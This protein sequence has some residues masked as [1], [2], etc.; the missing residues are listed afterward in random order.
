[1]F[2]TGVTMAPVMGQL[3]LQIC[4]FFGLFS[5]MAWGGADVR[6]CSSP[7]PSCSSCSAG[8]AGSSRSAPGTSSSRHQT[9]PLPARHPRPGAADLRRQHHLL[10][11]R[12]HRRPSGLAPRRQRR[13][14]RPGPHHHHPP[15]A[16]R[17][18]RRRQRLQIARRL[19]DIIA[20]TSPS[21]ASRPPRPP[22]PPHRRGRRRRGPRCDRGSSRQAVTQMRP[23]LGPLRDIE[24]QDGSP[25]RR[26]HRRPR[27]RRPPRPRRG[28]AYARPAHVVQRRRGPPRRRRPAP[29]HRRALALPHH[30]GGARQRRAPLH[31]GPGLGHPARHGGRPHAVRRGGGV[32]DGRLRPHTSGTGLGLLGIRERAPPT[33]ARSRS[34]RRATRA[35][36]HGSGIPLGGAGD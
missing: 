4:Y 20:T 30:P 9:T 33:A 28:A 13:V 10:R 25:A 32:D 21:S 17:R 8:S 18:R 2:V 27:R 12:D 16:L 36:G 35:T 34:A 31:R 22:R 15:D 11:R 14:R 6:R 23:L 29:P 7:A 26:P 1:M 5:A 24:E 3:S 19:H